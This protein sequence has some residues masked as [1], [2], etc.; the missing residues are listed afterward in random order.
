MYVL[1]FAAGFAELQTD[2]DELTGDMAGCRLPYHHIRTYLMA[3][4]FPGNREHPVLH[5]MQVRVHF[6]QES[7]WR[8][9]VCYFW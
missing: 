3:T 6:L 4:L 2:L 5:P 8:L 7:R 9:T 1:V